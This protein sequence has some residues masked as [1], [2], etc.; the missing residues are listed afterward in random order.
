MVGIPLDRRAY[1][2]DFSVKYDNGRL[3]NIRVIEFHRISKNSGQ[4][5]KLV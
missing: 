2:E 4:K 5:V 1:S 3:R